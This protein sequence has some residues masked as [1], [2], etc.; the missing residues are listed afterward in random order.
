MTEHGLKGYREKCLTRIMQTLFK[1][2]FN[3]MNLLKTSLLA[4]FTKIFPKPSVKGT[5]GYRDIISIALF[6]LKEGMDISPSL[7]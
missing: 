2:L 1:I 5:L 4:I 7:R 3:S 6:G